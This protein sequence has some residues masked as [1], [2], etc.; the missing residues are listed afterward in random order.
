MG[1]VQTPGGSTGEDQSLDGERALS[2][3]VLAGRAS[4]ARTGQIHGPKRLYSICL[5]RRAACR[6]V[7]DPMLDSLPSNFTRVYLRSWDCLDQ[8]RRVATADQILRIALASYRTTRRTLK[9]NVQEDPGRRETSNTRR[10]ALCHFIG[11]T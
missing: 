5:G 1:I 4:S 7:L 10:P 11:R 2:R 9:T 6:T 8:G 3:L